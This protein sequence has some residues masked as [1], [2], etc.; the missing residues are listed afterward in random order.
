MGLGPQITRLLMAYQFVFQ[1][2]QKWAWNEVE[3]GTSAA[4]LIGGTFSW[5]LEIM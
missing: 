4:H 2:Q 3:V 1:A 5:I